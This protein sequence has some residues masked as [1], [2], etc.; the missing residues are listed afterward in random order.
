MRILTSLAIF[1]IAVSCG[2]EKRK[3]APEVSPDEQTIEVGA[4]SE[5][6]LDPTRSNKLLQASQITVTVTA[7]DEEKTSFKVEGYAKTNFGNNK[8]TIEKN[9]PNLVLDPDFM[10]QLRE[11][12]AYQNEGFLLTYLG[13]EGD[14]DIFQ[15]S[16]IKDFEWVKVD[17][18]LCLAAK[19]VPELKAEFKLYGYKINAT[20]LLK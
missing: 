11:S 10:I 9:V 5:Y 3:K 16:N 2:Y 14:C 1:F 13:L 8:F 20:Y 19:N 6:V 17:A 4:Q 12:G 7:R 18:T 15:V